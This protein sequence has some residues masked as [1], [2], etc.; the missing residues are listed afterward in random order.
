MLF[1]AISLRCA[2]LC[3]SA[4]DDVP[5][6]LISPRYPL[7]CLS[8]CAEKLKL[9]L[10]GMTSFF[11]HGLSGWNFCSRRNGRCPLLRFFP[12]IDGKTHCALN[13]GTYS[14]C[15]TSSTRPKESRLQNYRHSKLVKSSSPVCIQVGLINS[16]KLDYVETWRGSRSSGVVGVWKILRKRWQ[17]Y[18]IAMAVDCCW[19]AKRTMNSRR[20]ERGGNLNSQSLTPQEKVWLRSIL[21]DENFLASWGYIRDSTI[22]AGKQVDV[23]SE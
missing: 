3:L 20:R 21:W 7:L 15:H 18:Q 23:H 11:R 19:R 10:L 2:L 9:S 4:W 22:F 16:G 12:P 5:I 17:C 1:N 14:I 8:E 6:M 13:H